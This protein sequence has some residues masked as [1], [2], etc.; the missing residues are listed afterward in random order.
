MTVDIHAGTLLQTLARRL[1]TD[2]TP[3]FE[4]VLT[5]LERELFTGS[6]IFHYR[7]GKPTL[8]ELGRPVMFALEVPRRQK[9]AKG[10]PV[11][12]S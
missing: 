3:S 2:R 10:P 7:D 4:D 11:S 5:A 6:I 12:G 8:L 9:V 1:P